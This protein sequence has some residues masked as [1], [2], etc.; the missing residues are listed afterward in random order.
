MIRFAWLQSRTQ[1]LI[2]FAGLLA[3][4][5]ALLI[6]GPEIV[7]L[8]NTII[9]PCVANGDCSPGTLNAFMNNDR[10]LRNSL[11]VAVIVVPCIIG[12]FW[13]APLVAREYESG[14]HR[15]AWTQSVT[16]T[17]WLAAKMGVLLLAAMI[18]AGL[19]SL[20]ATWWN[21]PFD[22][23]N[24][25]DY[26]MFDARDIVPIGYAAFGVALGVAAGALIRRT[27]PAMAT[28][29][30]GFTAVR[31]AFD[32]LVR[33]HLLAAAHLTTALDPTSTGFGRTN[34]GPA[35][36]QPD[37]PSLPNAWIHNIDIVSKTGRAFTS[38]LLSTMCPNL[39]LGQ[40]IAESGGRTQVPVGIKSTLE[41][42]I[43]KVGETY[44][45]VVTYHPANRYWAFQWLELGIYLAAALALSGICIW[46]IRSRRS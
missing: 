25:N 38:D 5:V 8:Y 22:R 11:N 44:H 23:V 14:T 35:T 34:S 43:S 30:V 36:L 10:L 12:I 27:L 21:S 39:V 41:D 31:V 15:L 7:H 9:R 33:Q 18:V 29:L 40:P 32:Q 37:T 3:A 28:V 1:T 16:R 13:G 17:R 19:L 46:S 4:A 2:V 42:C 6:T 45:L 24:M 26:G 20:M